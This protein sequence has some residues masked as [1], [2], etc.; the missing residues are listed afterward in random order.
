MEGFSVRK[1]KAPQKK[2]SMI[3]FLMPFLA[4]WILLPIFGNYGAFAS[5]IIGAFVPFLARFYRLTSYDTIGAFIASTLSVVFLAGV[6]SQIVVTL[7]YFIF[8]C[9]WLLSLFFRVPLCAWYSANNYGADDAFDN[10]L[11]I[12]TNKIITGFWGVLY[13][14]VS[15]FTWFLMQSVYSSFTGL[16]NSIAPAIAGIFTAIFVKWYPAYYARKENKNT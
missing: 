14:G 10:P 2:R 5:I 13:L 8:G 3:I 12:F 11:F 7:S 15:I 6:S 9:L 4:M 1:S 16:F